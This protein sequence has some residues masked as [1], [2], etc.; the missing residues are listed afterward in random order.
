[1]ALSSLLHPPCPPSSRG[2][3]RGTLFLAHHSDTIGLTQAERTLIIV[4]PPTRR[5]DDGFHGAEHP[6]YPAEAARDAWG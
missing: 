6:A 3:E 2:E 5:Q 1:M 4:T